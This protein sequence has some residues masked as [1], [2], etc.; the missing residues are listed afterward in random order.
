[1]RKGRLADSGGA[2]TLLGV[3]YEVTPEAKRRR[4]LLEFGIT[5]AFCTL[6]REKGPAE[7]AWLIEHEYQAFADWNARRRAWLL[8]EFASARVPR[9]SSPP[10][11]EVIQIG[12][13][14]QRFEGERLS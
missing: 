6:L 12:Y 4:I 1:M 2:S 9:P 11:K 14:Q 7:A 3:T 13:H 5:E 10:S 8:D